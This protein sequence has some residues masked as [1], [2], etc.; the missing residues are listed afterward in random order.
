MAASPRNRAVPLALR[1]LQGIDRRFGGALIAR[2]KPQAAE[3]PAAR[4]TAPPPPADEVR[5][6][7]VIRPGGLGDAVLMWPMLDALRAAFPAARL[8]VL[9][10]RRNA[11]AFG[12]GESVVNLLCYDAAPLR[13]LR[14]LRQARYDLIVDTEQYHH[15]SVLL[16]NALRPRWLCGFATLGRERLHTH[17]VTYDESTYEL[18]SFLRLAASVT[19]RAPHFD[20]ERRFLQV[21]AAA[22]EWAAQALQRA[23]GRPVVAIMPV[24]G[25]TYRLWPAERY[26]E[27]ARWLMARGY[28]VALLGG[29]DGVTV[30]QKIAAG[31]APQL[32]SNFA[33]RTG[34]AQTAGILG[35]ACLLLGA[36][37]GILH[38]AYGLGTPTVS[39]F[40]PALF[41]KWQPPGRRHRMVRL[42]LACSPCTR[43]GE[44]PPCPYEVACMSGITVEAVVAAVAELLPEQA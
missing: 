44:V 25:S 36:D 39:L 42:G 31:A 33:G 43:F 15:L 23:G 18:V 16:A 1:I 17:T 30:A 29:R 21:P 26:A 28:H 9:G 2:V 24:A 7:L 3:W 20:P 6:L 12:L 37:T 27:V 14:R 13:T 11:G 38:L 4:G 41:R 22:R 10:E 5:R 19:G 32:L 34:L 8:D 35:Q 40:G